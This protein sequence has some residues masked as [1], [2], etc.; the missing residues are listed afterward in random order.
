MLDKQ[1]IITCNG[2]EI[3]NRVLIPQTLI[4]KLN[5]MTKIKATPGLA[6][7][8]IFKREQLQLFDMLKMKEA[9]GYIALD[10]D[11]RII[12][13]GVLQPGWHFKL[14]KLQYWIEVAPGAING[15]QK[16]GMLIWQNE[17]II[18]N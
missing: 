6:M 17:K 9:I 18:S 1:I 4:E 15:L 11:K 12:D 7:L 10:K 2:H 3:A 16:G 13:T 5:G 14:I 8:W